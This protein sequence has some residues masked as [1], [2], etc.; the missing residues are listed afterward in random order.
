MA[1]ADLVRR[2]IELKQGNVK[3]S[4]DDVF[5]KLLESGVDEDA[6]DEAVA[7]ARDRLGAVLPPQS[8]PRRGKAPD[9]RCGEAP[10]PPTAPFRFVALNDRVVR[11]GD[12]EATP[13]NV[14]KPH[15]WCGSITVDWV[16]ETPLLV[17]EYDK[18]SDAVVGP[19]HLGDG[20]WTIPGSSLRGMLRSVLENIA[21][22][23]LSRFNGHHRYGLRNFD[24]PGYTLGK[25]GNIQ[26]GWLYKLPEKTPD[27]GERY[28]IV[29]CQWKKLEIGGLAPLSRGKKWAERELGDKYGLA[30]M[31]HGDIYDFVSVQA[32]SR[33]GDADTWIRDSRGPEHG[34]LVFSG[35]APSADR[36]KVEYVF[37]GT[38]GPEFELTADA[39]DLFRRLNSVPGKN[40]LEPDGSWALLKPTVDAGKRIPVFYVG[41]PNGPDFAF[42]LTRLFKVPH[43]YSV[44]EVAGRTPGHHK[45]RVRRQDG[46]FLVDDADFVENLFG[47][48]LE[49]DGF[50][51]AG[52]GD[53]PKAAARKGRVAFSFA[54]FTS[55]VRRDAEEVSTVMMAPRASFAPFYLQ[56]RVKDYSDPDVRLAGRKRYLPRYADPANARQDIYTR[57]RRQTEGVEENGKIQTKLHFLIPE[58]GT[59]IRFTSTIR[60]HN[61]TTAEIGGML[62]ALTH[63][64]QSA[65]CRHL[66]GRAKP[67]GAGQVRVDGLRMVLRP[68]DQPGKTE[69]AGLAEITP[70]LQAFEHRMGGAQWRQSPTVTEFLACSR[71]QALAGLEYMKG[72]KPFMALRRTV[73]CMDTPVCPT[74][75]APRLLPPPKDKG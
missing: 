31:R 27:G 67:F 7:V 17:G 40:R 35:K 15:G 56:G 48:V 43:R 5:E 12:D 42:G 32:F 10:N 54:Q 73:Q 24:H 28:R 61:L 69:S 14:P 71:P 57:L 38:G 21:L 44:A 63:G 4:W 8:P 13:L 74:F 66:L 33:S 6:L 50:D 75:A 45:P 34:V 9:R 60:L 3:L 70:Y 62:W 36:K 39:F 41:T 25:V 51:F 1:D 59:E 19:M 47:Y 49:E 29:P 23:R 52:D 37:H 18:G 65:T 46:A 72:P 30:A 2:C 20:Q 55:P 64:G 58:Q 11:A 53:R 22:G 68:N 16:A 26:A